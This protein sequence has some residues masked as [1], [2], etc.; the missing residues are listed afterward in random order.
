[1][2][3]LTFPKGFHQVDSNSFFVKL[4]LF[5]V[6]HLSEKDI[7]AIIWFYEQ[8]LYTDLGVRFIPESFS[9][10]IGK[11][12]GQ[13]GIRVQRGDADE[14]TAEPGTALPGFRDVSTK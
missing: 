13:A 10:G 5:T 2:F 4:T 1:M 3:L 7:Q 14:I 11:L 8:A 9:E 6:C 12:D